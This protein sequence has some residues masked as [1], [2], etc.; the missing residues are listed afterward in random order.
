MLKIKV[1]SKETV[2]H[3]T[4]LAEGIGKTFEKTFKKFKAI[5]PKDTGNARSKT[6]FQNKNTIEAH[7]QYAGRLDNGYSKKA[8]KGMV[9]PSIKFLDD[10]IQKLVRKNP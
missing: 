7:Y 3:M 1:N 2:K 9:E 10:E 6:R 8:P 5:T 4:Q